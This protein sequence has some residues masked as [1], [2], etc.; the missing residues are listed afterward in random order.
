MIIILI[1][2][3]VVT[4]A[5]PVLDKQIYVLLVLTKIEI[6]QITVLANQ[7]F[8]MMAVLLSVKL[9][10]ILVKIVLLKA[11]VHLV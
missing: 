10:Y 8:M 1:V 7:D 5:Q 3:L 4:N 9:V 2:L 6:L 11:I